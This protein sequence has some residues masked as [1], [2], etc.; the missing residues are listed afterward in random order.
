MN[1]VSN[2]VFRVEQIGPHR[3]EGD[4]VR[5]SWLVGGAYAAETS[6]AISNLLM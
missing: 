4:R 2:E 3:H 5:S 1:R 6:L